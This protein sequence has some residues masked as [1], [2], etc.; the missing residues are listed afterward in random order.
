MKNEENKYRYC[1]IDIMKTKYWG[2]YLTV[3]L[4]AMDTLESYIFK[5]KKKSPKYSL[6]I[7]L[8]R[9]WDGQ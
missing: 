5:N 6:N 2:W 4:D 3:F 8:H 1:L 9:K 7:Y